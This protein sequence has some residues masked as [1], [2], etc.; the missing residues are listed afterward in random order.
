MISA[1]DL[2]RV[3][4]SG[5]AVDGPG[6][7]LLLQSL[8]H[9]D[10][11]VERLRA[12]PLG[13]RDG[14]LMALRAALFGDLLQLR[15]R[16]PAC[17]EELEF[18]IDVRQLLPPAEPSGRSGEGPVLAVDEWTVAFRVPTVA[19]FDAA[20]ASLRDGGREEA[21]RSL[22]AACVLRVERAG[23]PASVRDLPAAVA[24]QVVEAIGRADPVADLAL[25]L[26]CPGCGTTTTAVLDVPETVW[27]ELEI[28]VRGTLAE[29]HQ[30]AAAYGWSEQEVLGVSPARRRIYLELVNGG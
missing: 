4:E 30:L 6:R 7:A 25:E 26:S 28:W 27:T 24:G 5:A 12:V 3:W 23:R 29:V 19:D 11:D 2:L 17:A 1:F 21:R 15:A 13:V 16:C 8:V 14:E 18:G 10:D 9:P 20:S 22:L